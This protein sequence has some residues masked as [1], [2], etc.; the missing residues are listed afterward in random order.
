MTRSSAFRKTLSEHKNPQEQL[1]S[2]EGQ[3]HALLIR[4]FSLDEEER[5]RIARE[6]YDELGQPMIAL[7]IDLVWRAERLPRKSK[8]LQKKIQTMI[9]LI[10]ETVRVVRR[11]AAT[12][13]G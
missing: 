2:S 11:I 10:D 8:V 3:F 7:K 5:Y 4:L 12:S 9:H 13:F 6:I 1:E